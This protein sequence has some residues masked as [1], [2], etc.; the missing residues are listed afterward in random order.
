MLADLGGAE[1]SRLTVTVSWTNE[2][3]PRAIP[4]KRPWSGS[5]RPATNGRAAVRAE[6]NRVFGSENKMTIVVQPKRITADVGDFLEVL[7]VQVEHSDAFFVTVRLEIY[8]QKF[9]SVV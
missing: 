9:A 6:K 2:R 5:I 4:K 7:F 1:A 3:S 8:I